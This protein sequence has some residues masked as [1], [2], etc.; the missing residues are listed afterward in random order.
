MRGKVARSLEAFFFAGDAE[1]Q[2]RSRRL[3]A[4]SR[5]AAATSRIAAMPDAL[6]IAPL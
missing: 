2:N 4:D 6:S 5:S 1:E 3:R